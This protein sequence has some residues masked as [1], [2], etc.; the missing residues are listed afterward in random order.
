MNLTKNII[1]LS[2]S[3]LLTTCLFLH[4]SYADTVPSSFMDLA[5]SAEELMSLVN[6]ASPGIVHIAVYDD[7]GALTGSGSGFFLDNKG[8]IIINAYLLKDAYSAEVLSES[9]SYSEVLV[10][11]RNDKHD[12]AAIKVKGTKEIP[13]ELDFGYKVNLGDRVVVMGKTTNMASTVSEGLVSFLTQ[14]DQDP[15]LFEIESTAPLLRFQIGK[16]GPVLNTYGKVIGITSNLISARENPALFHSEV[17]Y[18]VSSN[19]IQQLLLNTEDVEYLHP[20]RSKVWIKWF[21]SSVKSSFLQGYIYLY[22]KGAM[23]IIIFLTVIIFVIYLARELFLK[24]INK[25][26]GK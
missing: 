17:M 4:P 13:L 25:R 7:T 12:I 18:A 16:D 10:L 19:S 20:A 2:M 24:V 6:R 1:I 15:K 9:N 21:V 23:K 14:A 3:V 22:D 26:Y 8:V 5:G 11:S